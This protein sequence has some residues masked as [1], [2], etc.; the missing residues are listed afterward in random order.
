MQIPCCSSNF[1]LLILPS[2]T[3]SC[4][5]NYCCGVL[6]NIFHFP[7]CFNI[8]YLE[9]FSKEKLPLLLHSFSYLFISTWI[10]GYLFCSMGYNLI[11]SIFVLLLKLFQLWLQVGYFALY[12][13][14]LCF[15]SSIRCSYLNLYLSH[16]SPGIRRR[17]W[18]PTGTPVL[19][20]GKSHGRRSLVGC[21]P[22]GR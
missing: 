6:I 17:H 5:K 10:H 1:C 22:W 21:S 7:N 14:L 16:P 19:L 13:G 4:L 12:C 15:S 18:H 20:P 8:Y 11:Q 9:F 2:I 3:Q